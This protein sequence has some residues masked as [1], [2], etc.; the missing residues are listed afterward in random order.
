VRWKGIGQGS[1]TGSSS[2]MTITINSPITEIAEW[3]TQ[4]QLIIETSEGGSTSPPPGTYWK[5]KDEIVTLKATPNP[6][7][8]FKQWVKDSTVVSQQTSLN[9]KIII[10]IIIA[11][12]TISIVLVKKI[13]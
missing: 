10:A 4:Y 8:K 7:Y 3:K 9:L 2:S 5:D 12:V 11:I 1:Y 13:K 6:G